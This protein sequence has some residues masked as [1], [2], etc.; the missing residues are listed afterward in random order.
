MIRSWIFFFAV[1]LIMPSCKNASQEN[2]TTVF[3]DSAASDT[4]DESHYINAGAHSDDYMD[5]KRLE[6]F[7]FSTSAVD[8][9]YYFDLEDDRG[10]EGSGVDA[11]Y[12]NDS[13]READ[14]TIY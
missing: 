12:V 10:S 7:V 6:L 2:S 14:W 5:K 11:R 4:L 1:I 8:T 13:I 9:V 3:E